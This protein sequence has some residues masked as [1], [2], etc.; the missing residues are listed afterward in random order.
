MRELIEKVKLL[1][2]CLKHRC[3]QKGRKFKP[4]AILV[5]QKSSSQCY[6]VDGDSFEVI[7]EY[8]LK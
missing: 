8:V 2:S 1:L 6:C 3:K 4:K 7:S 5:L